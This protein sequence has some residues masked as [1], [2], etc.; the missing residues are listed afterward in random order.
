M[1]EK[2]EFQQAM[3]DIVA[4]IRKGG[5]AR[6]AVL[7]ESLFG[8]LAG[9]ILYIFCYILAQAFWPHLPLWI[10]SALACWGFIVGTILGA[11]RAAQEVLKEKK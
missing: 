1:T 6:N 2:S 10:G 5:D 7:A 9:A 8:A 3:D 11:D 4:A